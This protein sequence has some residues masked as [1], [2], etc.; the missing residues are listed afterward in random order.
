ML[1]Y[2]GSNLD[3][4]V[5]MEIPEGVENGGSSPLAAESLYGLEQSANL[6]NKK[7]TSTVR[8]FRFEPTMA[9]PSSFIDKRG[10]IIVLYVDDLLIFAKEKSDIERVKRLIKKAHYEGLGRS[11]LRF[12]GST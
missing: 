10:T 5:Y 11:L 9:E 8:S 4:E 3:K 7:I 6:W 12:W 1:T 2:L